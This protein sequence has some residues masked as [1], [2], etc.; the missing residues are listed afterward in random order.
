MVLQNS[1]LEDRLNHLDGVQTISVWL[2][3]S[4]QCKSDLLPQ[5]ITERTFWKQIFHS[6]LWVNTLVTLGHYRRVCKLRSLQMTPDRKGVKVIG[7]SQHGFTNGKSCLT[8]LIVFCDKII[9]F[10]DE[11]RAV[12]VIYFDFSEAFETVTHNVLVSQV[13]TLQSGWRLVMSGV[14]QGS[15]LEPLV[16]NIFINGLK[17]PGRSQ[18]KQPGNGATLH[19]GDK[20]SPTLGS[21]SSAKNSNAEKTP[22]KSDLDIDRRLPM[23]RYIRH[24]NRLT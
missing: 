15:I 22:A 20:S 11:R 24:A 12:Y 2:G 5:K 4:Q 6:P 16:F 9:V 7:N 1:P 18:H 21:L 14:P 8:N 3:D 17:R 13:R 10:V 23:L 19:T